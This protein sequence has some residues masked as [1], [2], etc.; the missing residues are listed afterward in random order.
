MLWQ[1]WKAPDHRS[2][3]PTP[4]TAPIGDK[5]TVSYNVLF[6]FQPMIEPVRTLIA[7]REDAQQT[8]H[9]RTH[10]MP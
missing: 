7:I 1:R 2:R 6:R 4:M 10:A 5:P 9:D 8:A 3:D